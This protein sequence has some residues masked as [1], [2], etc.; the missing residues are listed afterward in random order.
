MRFS[1]SENIF[2]AL[3]E[4]GAGDGTEEVESEVAGVVSAATGNERL[5]GFVDGSDEG[6]KNDDDED[7]GGGVELGPVTE[8]GG[9]EEAGAAEE[10]SEVENLIDVPE[11]DSL[12]HVV[13][14]GGEHP[15]HTEPDSK[16]GEPD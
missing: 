5:V 6:H 10:V 9:G 13:G 4:H 16:C 14:S 7:P 11:V 3:K 8:D 1:I 2:Q 15:Q 12:W